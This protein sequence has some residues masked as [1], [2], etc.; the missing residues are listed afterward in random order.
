MN[1]GMRQDLFDEKLSVVLTVSDILKTLKREMN[2]D[3]PWLNQ[4]MVNNRD[5]RIIYFGLTYHFGT[6]AK[7]SKEKSLQY[8][9]NL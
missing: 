2:L 4:N 9:N 7:K 5:T 6:Q 8:D 3:T 1:F